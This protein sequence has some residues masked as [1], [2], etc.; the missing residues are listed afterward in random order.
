M[1]IFLGDNPTIGILYAVESSVLLVTAVFFTIHQARQSTFKKMFLNKFVVLTLVA[2]TFLMFSTMMNSIG[3][4]AFPD[5]N[6]IGGIAFVNYMCTLATHITLVYLRSKAMFLDTRNVTFLTAS[7][8][9]VNCFYGLCALLSI[10]YFATLDDVL[11]DASVVFGLAGG[12]I[13]C[14]IEVASTYAFA[15]HISQ[16]HSAIEGSQKS[17][18]VQIHEKQSYL[19]AR[20]GVAI[21]SFGCATLILLWTNFGLEWWNQ[22]NGNIDTETFQWIDWSASC[23]VSICMILWILMKVEVDS[24]KTILETSHHKSTELPS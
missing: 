13:M 15:R 8:I 5:S 11:F 2:N 9:G 19:I 21:C 17:Q 4:L 24:M 3:F 20:R 7:V 18:G 16:I 12:V 22:D 1:S 23:L 14:L 10:F 6:A